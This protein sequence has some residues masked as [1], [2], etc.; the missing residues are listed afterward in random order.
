[1]GRRYSKTV[2]SIVFSN[3][4]HA[5]SVTRPPAM[6]QHPNPHPAEPIPPTPPVPP[7]PTLPTPTDPT[8]PSTAASPVAMADGTGH[9]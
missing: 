2:V 1:M 6:T 5:A 3:H 9:P 7:S 4:V 8:P